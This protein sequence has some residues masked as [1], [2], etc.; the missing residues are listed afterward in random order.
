MGTVKDLHNVDQR[1]VDGIGRKAVSAAASA[2]SGY[3]TGPAE[4]L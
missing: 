3:D 2:G 1:N 4:R